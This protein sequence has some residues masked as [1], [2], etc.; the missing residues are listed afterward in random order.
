MEFHNCIGMK[1]ARASVLQRLGYT[2]TI[3]VLSEEEF[4]EK[5]FPDNAFVVWPS[6][7]TYRVIDGINDW[8]KENEKQ[9]DVE[10]YSFA[11]PLT[12]EAIADD[13]EN[14]RDLLESIRNQTLH[15]WSS[16]ILERYRIFELEL[17]ILNEAFEATGID[18]TDYGVKIPI[19]EWDSQ[20]RQVIIELYK[21][22]DRDT[23]IQLQY[24]I[25]NLL[26]DFRQTLRFNAWLAERYRYCE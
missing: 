12:M 25:P 16:A 4:L 2:Y 11:F 6:A 20:A 21:T 7:F 26:A 17:H 9:A 15:P 18:V 5:H 19:P 1:S 13:W 22:L 23:Q 10:S 3:V 14:A 8:L 24:K